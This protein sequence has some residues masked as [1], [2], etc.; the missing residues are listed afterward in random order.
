MKKIV[1]R[2]KSLL[3]RDEASRASKASRQQRSNGMDGSKEALDTKSKE[4]L[5]K[6]VDKAKEVAGKLTTSGGEASVGGKQVNTQEV[7]QKLQKSK[8][9]AKAIPSFK[10]VARSVQIGKQM[11]LGERFVQIW[12]AASA[13]AKDESETLYVIRVSADKEYEILVDYLENVL[14]ESILNYE[15]CFDKEKEY[16]FF[17][18]NARLDLLL[19]TAEFLEIEKPLKEHAPDGSVV[20]AAF[21]YDARTEFKGSDR[22]RTFL[23]PLE[24]DR[25]MWYHLSQLSV[26]AQ[27]QSFKFKGTEFYENEKIISRLVSD[28]HI[29]CWPL[30]DEK[31]RNELLSEWL[32]GTEVASESIRSYFG[33]KIG[34]Y[35]EW[36]RWY[37]RFLAYPAGLGFIVWLSMWLQDE[38]PLLSLINGIFLSTWALMFNTF[39]RIEQQS[40]AFKWGVDE[41]SE[42]KARRPEFRAE[43]IRDSSGKSV[44]HFKESPITGELEPYFSSEKRKW[45]YALTYSLTT[46]SIVLAVCIMLFCFYAA[47]WLEDNVPG[48]HLGTI[49]SV[50]YS[51]IIP[52]LNSVYQG[53]AKKWTEM[54]NHKSDIQFENHLIFKRFLFEFPNYYSSLFYAAFYKCDIALVRSQMAT[55]LITFQIVGNMME[56]VLPYGKKMYEVY[57]KGS[58]IQAD[59]QLEAEGKLEDYEST[60]DDFLEMVSQFGYVTMFGAVWPLAAVFALANNILESRTDGIKLTINT[61]KPRGMQLANGIGTWGKVL[62]I[63]CVFSIFTNMLLI[64]YTTD[65][66]YQL[67][68]A[69]G[70]E[71]VSPLGQAVSLLILEHVILIVLFSYERFTETEAKWVRDAKR[72]REYLRNEKLNKERQGKLQK[73]L[74]DTNHEAGR[75]LFNAKAMDEEGRRNLNKDAQASSISA[76]SKDIFPKVYT[77]ILVFMALTYFFGA[78]GLHY[79]WVILA[80]LLLSLIEDKDRKGYVNR[81]R[82]EKATMQSLRK[83]AGASTDNESSEWLNAIIKTAWVTAGDSIAKDVTNIVEDVIR[84][85]LIFPIT[86]I[87]LKVKVGSKA[88]K[89]NNMRCVQPEDKPHELSWYFDIDLSTDMDIKAKA[90]IKA[91]PLITK[92]EDFQMQGKLK[93]RMVLSKDPPMYAESVFVQFLEKPYIDFRLKPLMGTGDIMAL[94]PDN[95]FNNI[96]YGA[97]KDMM[98]FPKELEVPLNG[99][100]RP[101]VVKILIESGRDLPVKDILT[102]SSDPYVTIQVG[103]EKRITAIKKR[104]LNPDWN[105]TFEIPVWGYEKETLKLAVYD[106]DALPGEPDDLMGEAFYHLKGC[107]PGRVIE[108]TARLQGAKNGTVKYKLMVV[109][110]VANENAKVGSMIFSIT[111]VPQYKIFPNKAYKFIAT[112]GACE[113]S[114]DAFMGIDKK[115][116][117]ELKLSLPAIVPEEDQ[118]V[119]RFVEWDTLEEKQIGV[120]GSSKA[121]LASLK[122]G[123]NEIYMNLKETPEVTVQLLAEFT[124]GSTSLD[125]APE[126][127][128]RPGGKA[129]VR[130]LK[131]EGLQPRPRSLAG[132]IVGKV[133]GAGEKPRSPLVEFQVAS[134]SKL[135]NMISH[136]NNPVWDPEEETFEFKVNDIYAADVGINVWH[137][138]KGDDISSTIGST[139]LVISNHLNDGTPED[140]KLPLV[141]FDGG[142]EIDTGDITVQFEWHADE[143]VKSKTNLAAE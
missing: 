120:V 45:I 57:K 141:I 27:D 93:I 1:S 122:E 106:S 40:V 128:V 47:D 97:I 87:R 70:Y 44:P 35:F 82:E 80:Y 123:E 114:T 105:Q 115:I 61:R 78:Y 46:L 58:D 10:S 56:V 91:V 68:V 52:V 108:Q 12:Q 17:T 7:L 5:R 76:P 112:C 37:T 89:F 25:C 102:R 140:I 73:F 83:I 21:R 139:R 18:L 20:K 79:L 65:Y 121:T 72:R 39:W 63:L 64:G 117:T 19:L 92:I 3:H 129:I 23:T 66:W 119:L 53:F 99:A 143:R 116:I 94:I 6:D 138:K 55:M 125:S 132:K 14:K 136:D 49:P 48:Y 95:I 51:I 77:H 101:S 42:D 60:F 16:L 9:A 4:D 126:A 100:P 71:G 85:Y 111:N 135:S 67:L 38:S 86:D 33:E 32:G 69:I 31:I 74:Q 130:L 43:M 75:D 2:S 137:K 90:M 28:E 22:M 131:A 127:S 50:G 41:L 11:T 142:E 113:D 26:K 88:I 59:P 8:K 103:L 104:N 81:A 24:R 134:E 110:K 133:T 54:E 107:E 15:K 36:L 34:F 30:H 13:R 109:P 84:A 124:E 96:V 118:L 29:E 62:H 98:V